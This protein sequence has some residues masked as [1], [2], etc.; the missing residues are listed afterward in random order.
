MLARAH[1]RETAAGECTHL[2]LRHAGRA[3]RG[4]QR[5]ERFHGLRVLLRLVQR[6]GAREG[7]LEPGALVG[8]DAARE[9][10]GVDSQAVGEPFDRSLGRARLAALDLGHVL[11]REAVAR[12]LALRQSRGDAELAEPLSETEPSGLVLRVVRLAVSLMGMLSARC[13]VKRILH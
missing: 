1:L 4:D 5:L 2:Q 8:R 3:R 12:E 13:L 10:A 7:S 11:L 9:E 6:L